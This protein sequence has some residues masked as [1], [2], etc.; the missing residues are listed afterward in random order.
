MNDKIEIYVRLLNEGTEVYRPTSATPLKENKYKILPAPNYD[1]ET[2]DWE[3]KPGS[4]VRGEKRKL[5]GGKV[6]VAVQ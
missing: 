2:E 3:F 6:L 1:P 5:S 4:I